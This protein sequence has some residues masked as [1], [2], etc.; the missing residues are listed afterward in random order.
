MWPIETLVT[1]N[2]D[3]AFAVWLSWPRHQWYYVKNSHK[4]CYSGKFGCFSLK[5]SLKN[6][7]DSHYAYVAYKAETA[8][9]FCHALLSVS[10]DRLR[11]LLP[12]SSVHF[13]ADTKYA[14]LRGF[15]G[16]SDSCPLNVLRIIC[17]CL[18]TEIQRGPETPATEWL[19]TNKFSLTNYY[20]C[21]K[22]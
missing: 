4:L 2:G 19:H 20:F 12:L 5:L 9:N 6:Y 15:Y 22:N 8:C 18:L 1:E 16:K 13:I 21:Y 11:F 17:L 14:N 3:M 7:G 10:R